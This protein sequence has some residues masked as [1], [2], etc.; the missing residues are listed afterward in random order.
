M[1]ENSPKGS[2]DYIIAKLLLNSLYGR[3]GMSTDMEYHL[4]LKHEDAVSYYKDKTVSDVLDLKNGKVLISF[5]NGPAPEN[6]SKSPN[7]SIATSA[8]V[9]AYGRMHMVPFK[10]RD[11]LHS[12]DTDAVDLGS[13][14]QDYEI[15]NKLGQMKLEHNF[16]E[17]IFLAPKFMQD[18]PT[19]M[20]MLK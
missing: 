3:L 10:N 20:N 13:P 19:N 9:T 16:K 5:F 11:D 1:K 15:G 18:I 12:T 4:I 6:S 2:A 14:L 17:A 7:I 8:S